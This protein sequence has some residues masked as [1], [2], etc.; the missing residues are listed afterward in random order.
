MKLLHILVDINMS[1]SDEGLFYGRRSISMQMLKQFKRTVKSYVAANAPEC[2]DL[3][4]GFFLASMDG[5]SA[6]KC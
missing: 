3:M 5:V 2:M 4:R 6:C 1:G